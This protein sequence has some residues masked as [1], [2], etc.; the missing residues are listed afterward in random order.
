MRFEAPK[1][2][3]RPIPW[4]R[5][6]LT[7]EKGELIRAAQ[8]LAPDRDAKAFAYD[9]YRALEQA[10]LHELSDEEWSRLENSDSWNIK[11]GDFEAVAA[12]AHEYGRDW[13]K[14]KTSFES[15]VPV[16]APTVIQFGDRLHKIG[17]N[18]RL[19]VARAMGIRPHV[20]LAKVA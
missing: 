20:L 17:G 2:P 10:S 18:T 14:F 12:L 15:G 9:M 3:E 16:P 5:P 7:V 8:S 4:T 19:M 1:S 11:E 6:E 13:E